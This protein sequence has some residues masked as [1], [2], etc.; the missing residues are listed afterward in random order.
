MKASPASSSPK[1]I[2]GLKGSRAREDSSLLLWPRQRSRARRTYLFLYWVSTLE[3]R[4]GER[5]VVSSSACL[6]TWTKS[7][8]GAHVRG[9]AY[10]NNAVSSTECLNAKGNLSHYNCALGAHARGEACPKATRFRA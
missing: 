10:Y 5:E 4:P 3:E 9:E 8:F 7:P 2:G 1:N 6:N